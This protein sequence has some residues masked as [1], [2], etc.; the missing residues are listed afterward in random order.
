MPTD[1]PYS[2]ELK[3]GHSPLLMENGPPAA[4]LNVLLDTMNMTAD[5]LI[6]SIKHISKM[7]ETIDEFP[8]E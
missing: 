8:L 6:E 7:T 4:D 3:T 2:N 1:D 5:E